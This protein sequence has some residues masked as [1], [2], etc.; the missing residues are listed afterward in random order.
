MQ[1]LHPGAR[2]AGADPNAFGEP[3]MQASRSKTQD[4]GRPTDASCPSA[5]DHELAIIA[6]AQ[7]NP[8]AFE[9]L[10]RQYVG[11]V[12]HY[13]LGRLRDPHRAEDATSQTFTRVLQALSS[14]KPERRATG[15]TFRSWLM[16][17]ARNTVIDASRRQKLISSLDDASPISTDPGPEHAAVTSSEHDRIHAAI[18]QLPESQRH[19]VE[20]RLVG[21]R[22]AEIAEVLGMSLGAVKTANYRAYQ[23]LRELLRE[24]DDV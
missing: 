15:T 10:Y 23:R 14:F 4:T 7:Q 11:L 17:I 9:P 19:I 24:T 20:L 3:T 6:A 21:L 16:T 12:Y 13:A 5:S 22:G 8:H 18:A 2:D 1:P